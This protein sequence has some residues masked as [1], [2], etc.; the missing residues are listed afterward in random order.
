MRRLGGM[1]GCVLVI[2]AAGCKPKPRP[3]VI[4]TQRGGVLDVELS[5]DPSSKGVWHFQGDPVFEALGAVDADG[6]KEIDVPLDKISVGKHTIR[7]TFDSKSGR[8]SGTTGTGSFSFDRT[9][10]TPSVKFKPLARPDTMEL[11]CEGNLCDTGTKLTV[12]PDGKLSAQIGGCNGCTLEI[13]GQKIAVK[14]DPMP[15]LIDLANSVG[16]AKTSEID[17]ISHVHI[18]VKITS[19]EGSATENL[20]MLGSPLAAAVLRRVAAGPLHFADDKP[21]GAPRSAIVVRHEANYGTIA[22]AGPAERVHDFDLVGIA[23]AT[24]RKLGSCGTYTK[25]GDPKTRVTV[26][27]WGISYDATMMD[28]RAGKSVGHHL[29]PPVNEACS[30][31]ITFYGGARAVVSEPDEKLVSAWAKTFLK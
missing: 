9:A 7:V 29:F 24:P 28:R 23:T 31:R 2:G 22:M 20:E 15:S 30:D 26:D 13:G 18:P 21:A 10:F 27:H 14:G 5:T 17:E 25:E 1:V 12:T 6:S 16:S 4:A 8:T 11:T 3:M 19:S